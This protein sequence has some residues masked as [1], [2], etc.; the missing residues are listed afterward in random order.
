M[1]ETMQVPVISTGHLSP[2]VAKLLGERGDNN[3]FIPCA[4]WEYGYFIYLDEPE[5]RESDEEVD[6]QCLLAIRDWLRAKGY[7]DG[8]VRLDCDADRV[9]DLPFYD[10]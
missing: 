9:P 3:P 1:H 7:R 10:W 2:E 4:V 5:A 6:I 8:W